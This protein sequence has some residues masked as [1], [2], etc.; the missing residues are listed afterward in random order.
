MHS[1]VHLTG[2]VPSTED[3]ITGQHL[4][5]TL[6]VSLTMWYVSPDVPLQPQFSCF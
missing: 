4:A 1:P 3:G 2:A 5:K 6:T